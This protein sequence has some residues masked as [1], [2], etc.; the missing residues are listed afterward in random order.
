[1]LIYGAYFSV[2]DKAAGITPVKELIFVIIN[3]S[4][5]YFT[6]INSCFALIAASLVI[7]QLSNFL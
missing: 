5:L 6:N 2:H 3:Y 7:G 1:M 4:D